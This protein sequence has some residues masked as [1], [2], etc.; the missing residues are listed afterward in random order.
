MITIVK[1]EVMLIGNRVI[2]KEERRVK[3]V[4]EAEPIGLC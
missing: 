2:I 1:T 4:L 3:I